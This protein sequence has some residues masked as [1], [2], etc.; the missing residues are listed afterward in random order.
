[1][2]GYL[3]RALDT[4][5]PELKDFLETETDV[6]DIGCGPGTITLDVANIVFPGK[7]VGYDYVEHRI[8]EAKKLAMEQSCSNVE[9]ISG[10]A[11]KLP[12]QSEIFNV[13]YSNTVLHYFWDPQNALKEQKRVLK[14]GGLLIAA[15]VRDWGLIRRYPE[16]PNWD[17]LLNARIKFAE[18][19]SSKKE[20]NEWERRPCFAHSAAGRK[21]TEWFSNIGLKI[22]KVDITPYRIQYNG[23]NTMQKSALDL[24]PWDFDEIGYNDDLKKEYDAMIEYGIIDQSLIECAKNEA[25][26]WINN[27]SSFHFEFTTFVVGQKNDK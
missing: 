5:F 2:D 20:K 9:F 10:D 6:L 1:M 19:I 23:A 27:P 11:N 15:G 16:C 4:S 22:I 7:V 8:E 14:N 18:I 24:L 13:V 21:C 3:S 25:I 17:K 12:F 26:E